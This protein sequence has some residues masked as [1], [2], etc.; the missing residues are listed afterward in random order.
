MKETPRI[1]SYV[2][3]VIT[4]IESTYMILKVVFSI[5]YS[6]DYSY[7]KKKKSFLFILYSIYTYNL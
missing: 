7:T 4:H 6:C 5:L 2:L 1:Y 3:V